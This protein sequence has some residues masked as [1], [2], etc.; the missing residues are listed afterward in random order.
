MGSMATAIMEKENR[1]VLTIEGDAD[2]FDD[3][4]EPDEIYE[5]R[6]NPGLSDA[7]V[8]EA[9]RLYPFSRG[10]MI[11]TG[12]PGAGK[13]LYGNVLSWKLKRYFRD[14]KVLR[15]ERPRRLYGWYEPFD[16]TVL[17]EEFRKMKV[18]AVGGLPKEISRTDTETITNVAS[19]SNKWFTSAGGVKL[20]NSVL[21]LTEF[22]R[23]MHNRNPFNPMG[24]AVG[25]ILKN[26]RHMDLLVLGTAQQKQELDRISCL[27]YVTHE[28][29]CQ[30]AKTLPNTGVYHIYPVRYVGTAGVLE[31]KGK[32]INMIIDGG[33]PRAELGGKKYFQLYN[34]KSAPQMTRMSIKL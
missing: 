7:E 32:M 9:L 11:V 5:T 30:W 14:K 10:V 20:Q 6:L 2:L 4:L 27:P 3:T 29:R 22:W 23:Y 15:D 25:G 19:I 13:D 26:W 8:K 16:E 31:M 1:D 33:R 18:V 12:M 17:M 24:I 34:S 21:Y 28:V